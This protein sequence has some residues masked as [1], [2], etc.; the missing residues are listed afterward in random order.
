MADLSKIRIPNGTEYNLKDAQARADIESLNGSLEQVSEERLDRLIVAYSTFTEK[1]SGVSYTRDAT[2]NSVTITATSGKYKGLST[3]NVADKLEVGATY[4][5]HCKADIISGSPTIRMSVR[6]KESDPDATVI[7]LSPSD[8]EEDEVEFVA[9]A[10]MGYVTLFVT[11][12]TSTSGT[13]KYTDCWIKKVDASATDIYARGQV[14]NLE[15]KTTTQSAE[16]AETLSLAPETAIGFISDGN[17]GV[18]STGGVNSS[19]TFEHTNYIDV[20]PYTTLRYK[21]NTFISSTSAGMAFYD[22]NKELISFIAGNGS[23]STTRYLYNTV[24]IPDGAVYA[25]FSIF[26]DTETYGEFEIYGESKL[27]YEVVENAVDYDISTVYTATDDVGL[28]TTAAGVWALYDALVTNYPNYV[29]KNTLTDETDAIFSNYEYV[30]TFGNLNDDGVTY[31]YPAD[32]EIEKPVILIS[33]GTHGYE[34]S[35][36]MSLYSLMRD[37]CADTTKLAGVPDNA[38]IKIIP[39]V[40]PSGYD[41][42]SRLNS[43]GVN[44][45]RNFDTSNWTQTSSGAQYSGA[46][47]ASEPE[48]RVYQAW[49]DSNATAFAFADIHNSELVTEISNIISN[50]T[51]YKKRFLAGVQN[52]APHLRKDREISQTANIYGYTAKHRL[53]TTGTTSDYAAEAGIRHACTIELSWNVNNTGKHSNVTIGVGA[54]ILGNFFVS[55]KNAILDALYA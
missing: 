54:E 25:R 1:P 5:M 50:D 48:T 29:T 4:K 44:I 23:D 53:T 30:F 10:Y 28:V 13:V 16:I 47:P 11:W 39:V 40:T 24:T 9:D 49:I 45:N 14:E 19:T 20:R 8:G 34:R 33:T 15:T 55:L 46:S 41:S 27:Y 32:A 37:I 52:V 22:A 12:A 17:G 26:A 51:A 43:N 3:I 38:T 21:Q 42:D 35:A 2:E 31:G 6:G 7:T 18:I 36:V